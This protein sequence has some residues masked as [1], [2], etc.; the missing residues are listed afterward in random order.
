M[1]PC[2][3]ID[4][5]LQ[6]ADELKGGN[7]LTRAGAACIVLAAYVRE[8]REIARERDSIRTGDVQ[9]QRDATRAAVEAMC[10]NHL[11]PPSSHCCGD[12]DREEDEE[13]FP[14]Q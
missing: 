14:Q 12:C 8:A 10:R 13:R 5:A 7:V 11:L 6:V 3:K 2:M 9:A 1:T 4:E